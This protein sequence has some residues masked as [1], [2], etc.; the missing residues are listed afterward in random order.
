MERRDTTI[1]GGQYNMLLPPVRQAMPLC[2]K[3]AVLLG[4]LL[5]S[6]GGEAGK[7]GWAKFAEALQAVDPAKADAL[8]ME[9]VTA[10]H[11]SYEGRPI[12]GPVDFEAHFAQRRGDVFPAMAWVLWECVRDFF[13]ELGTFAPLVQAAMAKAS[14]SPT[15]GETTT[16]SAAPSGS[17][18]ARGPSSVTVR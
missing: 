12:S 17:G 14:P 6:L 5:G 11:L 9:A 10:G 4:P 7:E 15:G 18:S 1:N 3:T 8:L 16:G 13:P 2:T